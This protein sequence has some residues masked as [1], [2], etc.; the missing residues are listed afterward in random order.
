MK[1][2]ISLNIKIFALL[3][4]TIATAQSQI[5]LF[6]VFPISVNLHYSYK[7]VY[8]Q[9]YSVM[10]HS[11]TTYSD[12]SFVDYTITDSTRVNDSTIAWNVVESIA[13]AYVGSSNTVRGLHRTLSS[14]TLFEEAWGFHVFRFSGL[15]WHFPIG[16]INVAR[17]HIARQRE[18]AYYWSRGDSVGTELVK[19]NDSLGISYV[20][21]RFSY[22]T[23]NSNWGRSSTARIIG[24]PITQVL[25]QD[26]LPLEFELEQNYP[27]PFNPI[28]MLSYRLQKSSFVDLSIYDVLGRL[29]TT[30]VNKYET[31]GVHHTLVN[32]SDWPSGVY[33]YKLVAGGFSKTKK[34][35]LMK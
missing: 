6:E 9:G 10:G 15:V 21:S 5:T 25:F 7:Y 34:M 18:A 32:A 17:Y 12:S 20:Y 13:P 2:F 19:L 28:T 29:R 16:S 14:L 23:P 24:T 3:I 22:G 11:Y 1:T 33:F 31:E 27:N 26:V 35:T 4:S 8:W 30:L